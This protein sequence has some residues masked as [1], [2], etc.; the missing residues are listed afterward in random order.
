MTGRPRLLSVALLLTGV[1][2]AVVLLAAATPERARA[3]TVGP[4]AELRFPGRFPVALPGGFKQG[5]RIP[6]GFVLLRRSVE[7]APG[8]R[9]TT[10][11][12]R[13]PGRRRIRTIG[14]NDPSGLGIRLPAGQRNYL[15]RS[16]IAII[17]DRSPLVPRGRP[18]RGRLYVL[19]GRPPRR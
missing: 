12:Y 13:C 14:L 7:L 17:A 19:C 1:L 4:Q 15:R 3:A 6:R 11:R 5:A 9:S 8:E 18:A 2:A 16:A 10:V